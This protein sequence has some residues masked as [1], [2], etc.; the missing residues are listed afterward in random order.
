MPRRAGELATILLAVA[1]VAVMLLL[2]LLTVFLEALAHGLGTEPN[3]LIAINSLKANRALR[4]GKHLDLI[5]TD[6]YSHRSPDPYSD[7]S[8]GKLSRRILAEL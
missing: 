6:Q 8:L 3:N 2:P 7:D 5:I 1:V 4:Y